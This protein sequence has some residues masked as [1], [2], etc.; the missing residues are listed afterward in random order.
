MIARQQAIVSGARAAGRDLTAE[1]RAEFDGLQ[2]QIDAAG[3]NPAQGAEGQG[4][5]DPT[6]GAR[7]MGND[8][9][10]QGTDPT[11]AARQAVATER[12]RVSDITALCRQAGMDPAEYIS[13]GATMDTVRQAAVDYLLKHGAPVSSR[14]NGD[15]GDNFRQAAVDAMLLRAGVDVQNPARGAEEMRGYSLRDMVIECMAR[16][17]MGTTTSLLRMSKDDLWNEACRQFF[18]PTAAF[19]AILD[20]AIKKNIVQKYQEIPTTFQL[21]TAKGSVPD[22]KPTKDHSYLAGGAGERHH[23]GHHAQGHYH[24]AEVAGASLAGEQLAD[25]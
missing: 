2:R 4:G 7:G 17:G 25:Q 6:G 23:R 24:L 12:Q 18:N 20:N 22:F 5:E 21:W 11:E 13:N 16:D 19:P 3:N 15:E 14:M 8:N 10:Q 1:E 9:G